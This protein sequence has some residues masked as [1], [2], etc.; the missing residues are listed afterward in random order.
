M[1]CFGRKWV[2]AHNWAECYNLRCLSV[3]LCIEVSRK[4]KLKKNDM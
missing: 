2:Y 1:S 4:R 3:E